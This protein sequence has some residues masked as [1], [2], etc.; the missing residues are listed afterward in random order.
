MSHHI[1]NSFTVLLFFWLVLISDH[2]SHRRRIKTEEKAK[3]IAA[4][5]G[6]EL[7]PFL[8]TLAIFH[9]DEFEEKDE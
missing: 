8:A 1:E 2:L 7:I 6:T 9:Q 5:W 3:V 4:L